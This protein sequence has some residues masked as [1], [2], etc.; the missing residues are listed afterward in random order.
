MQVQYTSECLYWFG[1]GKYVKCPG[2]IGIPNST[3]VVTKDF[4]CK[5]L[6]G[7]EKYSRNL[8]LQILIFSNITLVSNKS[9]KLFYDISW[10][11]FY[12][13]L[14][15]HTMCSRKNRVWKNQVKIIYLWSEPFLLWSFE[16]V[17]IYISRTVFLLSEPY[18]MV[19]TMYIYI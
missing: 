15:L 3:I 8:R 19:R 9:I 1:S 17:Y 5:I 14:H 12:T 13:F 4:F 6:K 16:T 2:L 7:N 10:T 18:I 11:S